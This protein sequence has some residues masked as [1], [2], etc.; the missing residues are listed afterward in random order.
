MYF[1]EFMVTVISSSFSSAFGFSLRHSREE[2][3][4]GMTGNQSIK[5]ETEILVAYVF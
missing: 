2:N 1:Y 4:V 5:T 3:H